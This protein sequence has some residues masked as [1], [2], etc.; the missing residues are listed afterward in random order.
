MC[1]SLRK[2]VATA[3]KAIRSKAVAIWAFVKMLSIVRLFIFKIFFAFI[4]GI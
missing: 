4:C 1:A 2:Y 3:T